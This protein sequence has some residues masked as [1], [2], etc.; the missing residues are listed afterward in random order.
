MKSYNALTTQDCFAW[1]VRME[2][3]MHEIPAGYT[4]ISRDW[5]THRSNKGGALH[6]DFIMGGRNCDRHYSDI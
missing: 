2:T 3:D 6:E 1:T 4:I 5:I